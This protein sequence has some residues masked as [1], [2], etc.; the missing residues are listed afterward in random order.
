MPVNAALV[1]PILPEMGE[2]LRAALDAGTLVVPEP[3]FV[4]R[5]LQVWALGAGES[6]AAWLATDTASS[7]VFRIARRPPEDMPCPM[8]DELRAAALIPDEAGSRALA[9]DGSGDNP[10]GC[11]YI[12][13]TFV[14]GTVRAPE[15]W[16]RDLLRAHARRLAALHRPDFPRAGR[17]GEPGKRLDIVEEF[18]GGWSWWCRTHPGITGDQEVVEL[19]CAV[20]S[21]LL[22]LA[23][24]F[25]GIGYS[26]IH[27]DLVATNVLVDHEGVPRYIDWEW[28]RIG[29]VANDLAL[30]GGTVT[31]GPWYV[32]MD[33]ATID[34]FLADYRDACRERGGPLEDP[35]RLRA[36]RDAW[37]L[38]ERF[39]TS[40][41]F[42]MKAAAGHEDPYAEATRRT[43]SGLRALLGG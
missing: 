8:A 18:D 22:S 2:R 13:S 9:M 43:R 28:A 40:L 30:I 41:H 33:E 11:P 27:G 34:E 37:E 19:A 7:L 24:A 10:L 3:G 1:D 15:Q 42:G 38:T 35:R 6:Y 21:R 29:D 26:V 14:P 20:R 17:I 23:P 12:V 32:P 36:R 39:L 4:S 5:R 25:E 16:D 31:G